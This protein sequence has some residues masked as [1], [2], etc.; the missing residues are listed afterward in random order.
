MATNRFTKRLA[1]LSIVC[2]MML[3]LVMGVARA[4]DEKVFV[5]GWDQEPG[6][7]NPLVAMVQATNLEEFYA[8]DV[9]NWDFDRKIYPVMVTEIPTIENGLVTTNE[10][11]N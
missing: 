8:R 4:Q 6:Q 2:V 10:K 5:I 9:W 1:G 7:L 11:G 3:T